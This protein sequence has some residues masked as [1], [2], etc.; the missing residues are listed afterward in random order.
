MTVLPKNLVDRL[1]FCEN[2]L[3]IF[4]QNAVAIGTSQASVTAMGVKTVAARA[5]LQAQAQAQDAAKAATNNL[6]LAMAALTDSVSDI[7]KQIKTQA[8]I[9]GP[10]VYSLA[11]IPAPATP[12]P[13]PAPG[14]P[15]D[16][17]VT[18]DDTGALNLKWKCPNPAGTSGTIYQIARR[19][20]ATGE[21][22]Y[23]G[24]TGKKS[25]LDTT[26]PA[27]AATVMYQIQAVRSTSAGPAAQFIVNFGVSGGGTGAGTMTASVSETTPTKM[28]A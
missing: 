19:I 2:H 15:T 13:T 20:G 21:L 9:V 26:L 28:A 3:S 14:K 24:G 5:A 25:F 17:T 12:S 7:I 22:E 6:N 27:G 8:A 11:E 23:I 10:S 4:G 16:L 18:L 1:Q